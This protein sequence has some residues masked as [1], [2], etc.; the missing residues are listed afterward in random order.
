MAGTKRG[1]SVPLLGTRFANAALPGASASRVTVTT[2][3]LTA[4]PSCAVTTVVMRL[5]PVISGMA[6]E[7]APEDTGLPLT[8]IVAFGSWTVGM[9]AMLVTPFATTAA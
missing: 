5:S 6:A 1:L 7:A 4:T 8:V 9:A 2:Y 3:V